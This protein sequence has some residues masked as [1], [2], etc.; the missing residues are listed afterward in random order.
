MTLSLY[1]S[2]LYVHCIF[3]AWSLHATFLFSLHPLLHSV[4]YA[5][6]KRLLL[7][8]GSVIMESTLWSS[9][10]IS[11]SKLSPTDRCLCSS[12][13]HPAVRLTPYLLPVPLCEIRAN[14][15]LG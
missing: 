3:I 1:S 5:N 2:W 8:S 13:A 11:P 14:F 9:T 7:V 15:D 6:I 4:P 12:G 10:M